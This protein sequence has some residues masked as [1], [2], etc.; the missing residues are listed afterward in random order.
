MKVSHIIRSR[1]RAAQLKV[2]LSKIDCKSLARNNVQL[3]LV[4]SASDDETLAIMEDYA[5]QSPGCVVLHADRM[6]HSIALNVGVAAS[7][8]ELI[9]FTD[10]DCYLQENYYDAV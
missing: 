1:N 9:I 5:R 3:V 10:D 2:T 4:D 6:G 7:N 8:G